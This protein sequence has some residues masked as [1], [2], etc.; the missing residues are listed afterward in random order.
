[1]GRMFWTVKGWNRI[2]P[3]E[4]GVRQS[5]CRPPHPSDVRRL[6]VPVQKICAVRIRTQNFY[7]NG[8]LILPSQSN[9]IHEPTKAR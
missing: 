1:M 5:F 8:M 2:L 9:Q 6:V 7:M 3:N 4:T